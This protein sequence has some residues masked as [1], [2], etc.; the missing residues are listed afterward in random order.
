MEHYKSDVHHESCHKVQLRHEED[1]RY[2]V[3]VGL[4][5]RM[6]AMGR[7]GWRHHLAVHRGSHHKV[8]SH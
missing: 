4:R 8:E 6:D 3:D 2:V 1:W 5:H 7:H